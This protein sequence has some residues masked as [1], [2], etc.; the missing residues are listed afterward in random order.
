MFVAKA[1]ER[2]VAVALVVVVPVAH[3]VP[4]TSVAITTAM[5]TMRVLS[6]RSA[7]PMFLFTR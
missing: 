3:E 6:L 5:V 2:I 1:V 7:E 4:G